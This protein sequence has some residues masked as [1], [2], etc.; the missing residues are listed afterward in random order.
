MTDTNPRELIQ[1]LA[2]ALTN[3]IRIIYN[4]DGTQH[5]S[6]ATPVLDEARVFLSQPEPEGLTDEGLEDIA[7]EA[8]IQHM[9]EYGGLTASKPDGIHA[10]LRAQRI[11]GLRAVADWQ[12][13]QVIEWLRHNLHLM[14]TGVD[15]IV[16]NLREAMRP[17]VVDLPQANS[18][19]CGEKGMERA[20][21]RT[22]EENDELM[23]K[24]S[25]S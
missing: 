8:E 1:R 25:D 12:L 6:T 5:I 13:E 3:A 19:V 22:F 7:R 23:R 10:Q 21:Q 17:K 15:Y 14:P 24:L 11:A 18:D 20:L 2:D 4:E 16:G 9:K